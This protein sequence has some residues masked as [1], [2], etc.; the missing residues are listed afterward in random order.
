MQNEEQEARKA[1]NASGLHFGANLSPPGTF[2]HPVWCPLGPTWTHLGLHWTPLGLHLGLPWG[3]FG[4]TWAPEI[5]SK[6]PF[7]APFRALGA[8][9]VK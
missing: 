2:W 4:I 7:G 8:K 1:K 5:A 3:P 6:D 9:G